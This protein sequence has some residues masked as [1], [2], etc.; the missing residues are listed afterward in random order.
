MIWDDNTPRDVFLDF[1][2]RKNQRPVAA[3]NYPFFIV[4]L[5]RSNQTPEQ[6]VNSYRNA[7]SHENALKAVKHY[8]DFLGVPRT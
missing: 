7:S 3:K 4:K 6:F 5:V 2:K 8:C 1:T